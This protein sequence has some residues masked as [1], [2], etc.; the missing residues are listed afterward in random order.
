MFNDERF[1]LDLKPE[2]LR[3]QIDVQTLKK[4]RHKIDM[5]AVIVNEK[6]QSRTV[7]GLKQVE[8]RYILAY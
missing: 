2:D 7:Y 8:W 4:L 6:D 3:S 5:M 1:V